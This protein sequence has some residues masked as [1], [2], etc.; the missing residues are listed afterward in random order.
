[1]PYPLGPWWIKKLALPGLPWEAAFSYTAQPGMHPSPFQST[2]PPCSLS[3]KSSEPIPPQGPPNGRGFWP[4]WKVEGLQL[5]GVLV[6]HLPRRL[7]GVWRLGEDMKHP[8]LNGA[9]RP[10]HQ[11]ERAAA[12]EC[13][14]TSL[15]NH[16]P[17]PPQNIHKQ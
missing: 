10:W 16:P 5:T 11:E 1:M 15:C 3:D 9:R 4:V 12:G 7:R 13:G 8:H 2:G 14:L 6:P 17:W